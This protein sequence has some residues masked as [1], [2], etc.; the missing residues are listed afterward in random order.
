M[1]MPVCCSVCE[2]NS[3]KCFECILKNILVLWRRVVL[4]V[5]K[6][7]AHVNQGLQRNDLLVEK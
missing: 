6:N 7:L 1:C 5:N 4:K 2:D 3:P